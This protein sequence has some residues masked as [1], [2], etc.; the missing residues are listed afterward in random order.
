[1]REEAFNKITSICKKRDKYKMEIY[2]MEL[3]S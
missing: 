1:M 3:L 2:E